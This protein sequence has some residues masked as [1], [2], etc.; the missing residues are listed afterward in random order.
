MSVI[1][2]MYVIN[3]QECVQSDNSCTSR[4]VFNTLS[5]DRLAVVRLPENDADTL[6]AKKQLFQIDEIGKTLGDYL[7]ACFV[8]CF[9]IIVLLVGCLIVLIS[10]NNNILY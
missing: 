1:V 9:L 2:F 6:E 8:H 3:I 5:W 7:H 10:F 4:L